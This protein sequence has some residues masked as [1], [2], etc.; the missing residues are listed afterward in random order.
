LQITLCQAHLCEI[1]LRGSNA[2]GKLIAPVV[3]ILAGNFT[4]QHLDFARM[5]TDA[6]SGPPKSMA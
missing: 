4:G 2:A 5:A 3:C 1:K 6:Q